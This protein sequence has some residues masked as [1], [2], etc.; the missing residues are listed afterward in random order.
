[1]GL[2]RRANHVT[3]AA[4]L[5]SESNKDH[6]AARQVVSKSGCHATILPQPSM[7]V[8]PIGPNDDSFSKK[9]IFLLDNPQL[10]SMEAP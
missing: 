9:S 10:H 4:I 2:I 7:S 3:N 5:L 8:K 6:R 1:M